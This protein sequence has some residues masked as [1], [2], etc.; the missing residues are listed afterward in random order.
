MIEFVLSCSKTMVALSIFM[1]AIWIIYLIIRNPSIASPAWAFGVA[2]C[3]F[4][5]FNQFPVTA[6]S[7]LIISIVF[8]WALRLVIYLSLRLTTN[9]IDQRYIAI[10]QYFFKNEQLNFFVI[11]QAEA[12]LISIVAAPL[13]LAFKASSS[14]GMLFIIGIF[15][16]IIG[17]IGELISDLQLYT[18]KKL[19]PRSICNNGFW[20]YSRHPNY[21]FH[22]L[23]WLGFA[24]AGVKV[25]DHLLILLSP[26]ILFFIMHVVHIN[27]TEKLMAK[28]YAGFKEYK[29]QTRKFLIYSKRKRNK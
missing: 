12:V 11:F 1:S 26:L 28:K 29:K 13:Y 7:Y 8:L 22:V 2:I 25:V 17:I 15:I 5:Y 21:F 14:V 18:F 20:Q 19:H 10:N 4:I 3:A 9:K 16:A 6:A 27:L 23:I 24:I